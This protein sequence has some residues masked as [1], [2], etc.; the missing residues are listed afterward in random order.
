MIGQA[1]VQR[2]GEG[3]HPS[4]WT[5]LCVLTVLF[6]GLGASASLARFELTTAAAHPIA[7]DEWYFLSCAARGLAAGQVPVAGCHDTKS[8]LIFLAHQLTQPDPWSY[9][10]ARVKLAA[11]ALSGLVV[12]CAGL[13]ATRVAGRLAG[14]LAAGFLLLVLA[15]DR[16][17]YALKTEMLGSL[18]MLAAL[19]PLVAAG[20]VPGPG[21]WLLSGLLFG[22]ALMS[23][24]SFVFGMVGVGFWWCLQWLKGRVGLAPAS[25]AMAAFAIGGL[26]PIA[27]LALVFQI[28]GRLDD[29]LLS[30]FVYPTVYAAPSPG[31][32]LH[33]VAWRFGAL[34]GILLKV[35]L[36]TLGFAMALAMFLLKP[37]EH[38]LEAVTEPVAP[39]VAA[40]LGMLA[41][42]LVAAILFDY[43]VLPA[44]TLMAVAAGVLLA[45][46]LSRLP[47]AWAGVGTCG[48]LVLALLQGVHSW[49]TTGGQGG[50]RD[51]R[52][53]VPDLPST[54]GEYGYVIGNWPAFFV[55]TRLVP[56]SEVMYPNALPGAPSSWAYT[57]PDPTT[58]KGAR[59]I[60]H[61]ERNAVKL[62]EDFSRTPP[63]WIM[64][65][66]A[67]ARA[68]G[69]SHITDIK[70]L[71]RYIRERCSLDRQV[72]GGVF[73]RGQ[74]YA[75]AY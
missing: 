21:A 43:H 71:D 30:T 64:V 3:R 60:A 10:I 46:L 63:R 29:F 19:W 28:N 5:L 67:L 44:W 8:P 34:S 54:R 39:V 13:L 40:G 49:N 1:P 32:V 20:R 61:Q 24:Q 6:V 50:A 42:L 69:S 23:K 70:V 57:P 25:V 22:L 7:L 27:A 38:D 14:V 2:H 36:V 31:S 52:A 62:A 74:L 41:L 4:V 15:S 33:Q 18:F 55:A 12:L 51:S 68:P 53:E 56:A 11:Y 26:A 65:V 9:D 75:C 58:P 47:T 66:A 17:L 45:A 73:T 72:G 16:H 59:L 48:V 37:R 35:P